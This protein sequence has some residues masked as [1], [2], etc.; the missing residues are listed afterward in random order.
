MASDADSATIDTPC[1]RAGAGMTTGLNASRGSARI[2]ARHV[3]DD[4]GPRA[5]NQRFERLRVLDR[6]LCL[7]RLVSG[8]P[9]FHEASIAFTFRFFKTSSGLTA[10]PSHHR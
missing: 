3:C 10:T 2:D 8:P 7:T 6:S 5:R 4:S 1:A 9:L